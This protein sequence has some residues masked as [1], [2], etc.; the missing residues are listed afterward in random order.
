M[1]FIKL[2]VDEIIINDRH[3]QDNIHLYLL[4]ICHI[5]IP[6]NLEHIQVNKNFQMLKM[7]QNHTF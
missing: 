4:A 3:Y 6:N 7:I 1:I 2:L 5:L